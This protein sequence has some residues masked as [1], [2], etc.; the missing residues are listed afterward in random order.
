MAW[1]INPVKPEIPAGVPHVCLLVPHFGKVSMEWVEST[2]GPLRF[3]GNASFVKSN[4]VARGILN[5]DVERNELVKAALDDKTV[6]H[7]LW[8]D[9]DC[10]LEEPRNPDEAILRLLAC[11][12]P[13][14][15]GLYRAKKA[16]G[17]YPYA[18]WA[19]NPKG[20]G[21]LGIPK[22]TG[23]FISVD[24]IG[25]GFCLTRREVWEKIPFPW[26]V[27]D[28]PTPSEDFAWCEKIRKAGYEIKVYTDVKLSHEGMMKVLCKDGTVHVLDV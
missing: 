22:W 10:I 19:K 15:S 2:Y 14:V 24:A 27:W 20:D 7:L 18:M 13:I 12:T 16:K 3:T 4:R 28:K 26:F 11:N 17:E 6:T 9:S 1:Q 5:L 21:Y 25:F 23:N 8:L